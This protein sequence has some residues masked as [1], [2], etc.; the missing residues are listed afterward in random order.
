MLINDS[1]D[2]SHAMSR[3]SGKSGPSLFLD[4]DG[5]KDLR[6]IIKK[7]FDRFDAYLAKLGLEIKAVDTDGDQIDRSLIVMTF[8]PTCFTVHFNQN[9]V[10][11]SAL[12]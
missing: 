4:S 1:L 12:Q 5:S 6:Y 10:K 2:V 8:K 11:I 3:C 7:N 9:F